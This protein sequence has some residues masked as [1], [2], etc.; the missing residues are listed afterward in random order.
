MTARDANTATAAALAAARDDDELRLLA[1]AATCARHPALL[2]G[3]MLRHAQLVRVLG[4][5]MA[6]IDALE[7]LHEGGQHIAGPY[8][9]DGYPFA[10][11]ARFVS[12]ALALA[13]R[14]LY[15]DAAVGRLVTCV[16]E[17]PPSHAWALVA[18]A[19]RALL[20][21]ADANDGDGGAARRLEGALSQLGHGEGW[22]E[23]DADLDELLASAQRLE[24][25]GVS[26]DEAERRTGGDEDEHAGADTHSSQG[27]TD[28]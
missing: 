14:E 23:H 3:V 25:A 26:E 5:G 24:L 28:G 9:P 12:S 18:S 16:A 17:A 8:T 10:G 20:A 27:A 19:S 4:H 21:V 2:A 22:G 6:Q 7:A 1:V 13:T 15:Q 11:V